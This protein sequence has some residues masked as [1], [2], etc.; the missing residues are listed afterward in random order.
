MA[1]VV[2]LMKYI[3]FIGIFWAGFSYGDDFFIPSIQVTEVKAQ[4]AY[5][6]FKEVDEQAFT[7]SSCHSVVCINKSSS[8]ELSSMAKTAPIVELPNIKPND[9]VETLGEIL[10]I[11]GQW[12]LADNCRNYFSERSPDPVC[13]SSVYR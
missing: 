6:Y 13:G 2:I 12:G 7:Q 5:D 1:D 3:A 9:T 10:F 4:D 11:M 8:L